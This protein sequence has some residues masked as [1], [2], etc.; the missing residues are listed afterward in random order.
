MCIIILICWYLKQRPRPTSMPSPSG[1]TSQATNSTTAD[2][3]RS[4]PEI[5]CHSLNADSVPGAPGDPDR[6]RAAGAWRQHTARWWQGT[7]LHKRL[8]L[9]GADSN[10][11]KVHC[12]FGNNFITRCTLKLQDANDL[13]R[14]KQW[15]NV[16]IKLMRRYKYLEKMLSEEMK[17]ILVYLRGFTEQH[18]TR[19]AQ[20]TAI[21]CCSG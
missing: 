11:S 7:S 20:I 4:W 18:R 12:W 1:W 10:L 9:S 5:F 19:L 16:I 3:A 13:A 17:K 14:I 15:D 8:Y 21:W 2:T 6:R